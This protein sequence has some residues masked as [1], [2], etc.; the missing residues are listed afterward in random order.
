MEAK[1][2]VERRRASGGRPAGAPPVAGPPA[3]P[4][5]LVV[6]DE[7]RCL[8]ANL[9]C[10]LLGLSRAA[11]IGKAVD[12][13]LAPGMRSRL[14]HVWRAFHEGGGHAGP[15]ELGSE[16][17]EAP[18]VHMTVTASV[19]PG[20]HLLVL[21]PDESQPAEPQDLSGVGGAPAEP[22]GRR[23]FRREGPSAREREVLAL[24]ASGATDEQIAEALALSPA[25]VQTHVRNAKAKLGARTRAQAVALALQQGLISLD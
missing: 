19:L 1:S 22:K 7:R 2:M 4:A 12:D 20:R 11:T 13:R 24:T 6:D 16:T 5:L 17:A 15:F 3:Q 21:S 25:T 8:E 9:A 14:D 10:R 23:V 18:E